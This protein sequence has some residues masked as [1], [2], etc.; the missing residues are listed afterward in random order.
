MKLLVEISDKHK[1]LNRLY[2]GKVVLASDPKMNKTDII[3]QIRG[4]EGV[5]FVKVRQDS[6]VSG[7][8]DKTTEYTLLE[9]KLLT[10][11]T[12][13]IEAL[14]LIRGRVFQGDNQQKKILGVKGFYILDKTVKPL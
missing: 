11:L 7:R 14:K 1:A 10:G 8:G 9:I 3:N 13:P 6:H 12:S 2:I 4:V 5:V